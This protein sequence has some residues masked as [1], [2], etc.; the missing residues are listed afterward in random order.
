[1]SDRV[2]TLLF[3]GHRIDDPERAS[4]RFP[5]DRAEEARREIGAVIDEVQRQHGGAVAGIGGAASGGDILFHE[6][7]RARGIPT[8]IYLALPP[9]QYAEK[10]VDSAGADW[11]QRFERLVREG[12]VRVLPDAKQ[13]DATVWERS[14]RRMLDDALANGAE[15]LTLIALWD[16]A[17]GDGKG[18]TSDMVRQVTR[19]GGEVRRVGRGTIFPNA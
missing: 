3:T 14:N 10:S 1:M 19:R 12:P 15:Q 18:G 9:K 11:K 5:A 17:A 16:G 2:H 7:C 4:P 8:T 13:D 6:E